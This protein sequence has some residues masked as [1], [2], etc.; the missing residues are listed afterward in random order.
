MRSQG[1]GQ[2]RKQATG[3]RQEY[4]GGGGGDRD[5]SGLLDEL[6][7][8]RLGSGGVAEHEH[9]DVPAQPRALCVVIVSAC[10]DCVCFSVCACCARLLASE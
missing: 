6:E 10:E 4:R 8:L 2:R 3:R 9:V 7:E 1:C 5:G